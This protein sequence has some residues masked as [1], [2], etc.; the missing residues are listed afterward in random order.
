[1]HR[2]GAAISAQKSTPSLILFQLENFHCYNCVIQKYKTVHKFLRIGVFYIPAIVLSCCF[3]YKCYLT[4]K[5]TDKRRAQRN[6]IMTT[7]FLLI[8]LAWIV[9]V[10]PHVIYVDFF[11][12]EKACFTCTFELIEYNNGLKISIEDF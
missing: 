12:L 5:L 1:M 10:S 8:C 4:L 2:N 9:L 6:N 11:E 3:Y 7:A